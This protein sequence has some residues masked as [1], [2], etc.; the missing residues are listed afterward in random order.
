MTPPKR[1]QTDHD[2]EPLA[3]AAWI[4]SASWMRAAI[5]IYRVEGRQ[6]RA[7]AKAVKRARR[8]IAKRG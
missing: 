5:R 6:A 8:R 2:Q 4:S 3:W 1:F 7:D